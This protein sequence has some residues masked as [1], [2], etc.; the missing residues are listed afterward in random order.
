MAHD[1]QALTLERISQA[2]AARA[3]SVCA[4]LDPQGIET[5]QSAAQAGECFAAVGQ[6]GRVA[7]ALDFGGGVAWVI[8]AAGGGTGMA[9]ATLAAV[10]HLARQRGCQLVGFQ[11]MR[12]GLVRVASKRGYLASACG[13]GVRLQKVIA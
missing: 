4:G 13:P 8:A 10:E 9:G 1:A 3:F 11:T 5:P 12:R 6:G 2:E 7:L